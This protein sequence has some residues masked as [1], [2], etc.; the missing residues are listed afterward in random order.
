[1]LSSRVVGLTLA[2]VSEDAACVSLELVFSTQS[3]VPTT[4]FAVAST[5]SVLSTAARFICTVPTCA[6]GTAH[7][8][9]EVAVSPGPSYCWCD[10]F[11]GVSTSRFPCAW[12]KL[13]GEA[14][15]AATAPACVANS[16]C[17]VVKARLEKT[18]G[19]PRFQRQS[20][21][22]DGVLVGGDEGR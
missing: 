22:G 3:E 5:E 9:V 12:P 6:F 17:F 11:R 2:L 1:M 19:R 7:G 13:P 4:S 16:T 20:L 15:P 18:T 21:E 8:C 14:E 10:R